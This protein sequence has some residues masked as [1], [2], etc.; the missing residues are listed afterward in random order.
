MGITKMKRVVSFLLIFLMLN[1][2]L[3]ADAI[4]DVVNHLRRLAETG[5]D[6]GDQI[7][8]S[9]PDPFGGEDVG[10]W[11][12][13][14]LSNCWHIKVRVMTNDCDGIKL[15]YFLPIALIDVTTDRWYSPALHG[16]D[17]EHGDE[18]SG[19]LPAFM[20]EAARIAAHGIAAAV[21]GIGLPELARVIEN[22][23]PRYWFSG[24]QGSLFDESAFRWVHVLQ[25]P[26]D[27]LNQVIN[28]LFEQDV[29][30]LPHINVFISELHFL[31]KCPLITLLANFPW[32]AF[33]ITGIY[34]LHFNPCAIDAL[35]TALQTIGDVRF[36]YVL[37]AIFKVIPLIGPE[38]GSW[39]E[40]NLDVNVSDILNQYFGEE[41]AKVSRYVSRVR[42]IAFSA[43]CGAWG[44][45]MPYN[46]EVATHFFDAP[47]AGNIAWRG[48]LWSFIADT[49]GS[50][51][52]GMIW[53]LSAARHRS[54]Y[55]LMLY[56]PHD[57][58]VK[59]AQPGFEPTLGLAG[60]QMASPSPQKQRY[61]KA[62]GWILWEKQVCC[63]EL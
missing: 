60:A 49:T 10:T 50:G 63:L 31:W 47:D 57:A 38:L 2:A 40:Q 55:K 15:E 52:T 11:E 44:M 6:A 32:T 28:L 48:W 8:S 37:S 16:L 19:E 29:C 43:C 1:R 45:L 5:G 59:C 36:G 42:D 23:D 33:I 39:L 25:I 56:W 62:F 22:T 26:T 46:G 20:R 4:T 54:D 58:P 7:I 14:L 9:V 41:L 24:F 17:L 21:R 12:D 53:T 27:V 13:N 30:P 35:V 61:N 34:L 51:A 18:T 3:S